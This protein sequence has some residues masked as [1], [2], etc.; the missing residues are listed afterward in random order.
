MPAIILAAGRSTRMG[1]QKL[2]MSFGEGPMLD[3]VIGTV[4]ACDFDRTLVVVSRETMDLLSPRSGADYRINPAPDR[5]QDS[6]LRCALEA[7]DFPCPF[8][9]FLGDKPLITEPQIRELRRRFEELT[10]RSGAKSALVPRRDGAPG[11]PGFYAPLWRE[12]FLNAADSAR[13]V[14]R[15][16]E[17]EI[18]WVEG[19]DG[20][21]FD[22]DTEKD[23]RE[24][25]L[26]AKPEYTKALP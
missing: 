25:L 17:A 2:L 4:L 20:C 12:R 8:A 9:I 18:E 19:C 7:M 11:H 5:G 23:Y 13:S 26:K 14:L 6:S 1:R 3:R 15:E 22:V 24:A 10:K 16:H 21:F